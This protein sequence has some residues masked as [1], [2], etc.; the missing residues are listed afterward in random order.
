MFVCSVCVRVCGHVCVSAWRV[1]VVCACVCVFRHVCMC[2]V[3]V[4]VCM[5]KVC[6]LHVCIKCV[7]LCMHV[8]HSKGQEF[9]VCIFY[10]RDFQKKY[11]YSITVYLATISTLGCVLP[12]V[13]C[14]SSQFTLNQRPF[15]MVTL[16]QL[17]SYGSS[18]YSFGEYW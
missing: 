12:R 1:F 13:D 16:N 8:Y 6:V 14:C 2:R 11:P 10:K 15:Q 5:C 9:H 17:L 18:W 7:Y 4:C 3:C